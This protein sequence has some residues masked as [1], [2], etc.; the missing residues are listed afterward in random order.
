MIDLKVI[1]QPEHYIKGRCIEPIEVIETW[2]LCH[3]LACVVKYIARCGRKENAY[4]DL[5][6]AEWYLEREL[7]LLRHGSLLCSWYVYV[8]DKLKLP[9]EISS[10]WQ[11]SPRLGQVLCLLKTNHHQGIKI[12][13]LSQALKKLQEEIKIY[14]YGEGAA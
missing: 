9:P 6:K 1:Q 2:G 5:K 4:Q 7:S 14:E 13:N 8:G 11:L 12:A 10:D 3:H